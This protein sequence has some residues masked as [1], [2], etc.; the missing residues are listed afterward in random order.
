MSGSGESVS[1]V[2]RIAA[3]PP[4]VFAAWV[5]AAQLERWPAPI[6]RVDGRPGGHFHPEV[7]QLDALLRRRVS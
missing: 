1:V 7:R 3:A 2:R 6:A 4:E 5:D